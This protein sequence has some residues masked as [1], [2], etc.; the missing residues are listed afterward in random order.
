MHH[1]RGVISEVCAISLKKFVSCGRLIDRKWSRIGH[2]LTVQTEIMEF[3]ARISDT[4]RL[5]QDL[6]AIN[7]ARGMD[8]ITRDLCA[9]WDRQHV[10]CNETRKIRETQEQLAYIIDEMETQKLTATHEAFFAETLAIRTIVVICTTSRK[11]SPA[12]MGLV[13]RS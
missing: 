7:L 10:I 8:L 2:G 5:F 4:R 13:S 11:S 12:T 1:Q 6:S 3:R 9:L